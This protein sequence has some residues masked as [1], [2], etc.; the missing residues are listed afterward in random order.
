MIKD[1]SALTMYYLAGISLREID[2]IF[3]FFYKTRHDI[4]FIII[5]AEFCGWDN[6]YVMSRA[7]KWNNFDILQTRG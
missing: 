3:I 5:N 6:F 7:G 1:I 2:I 4:L